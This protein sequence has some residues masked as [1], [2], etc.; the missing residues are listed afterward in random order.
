MEF[1][2]LIIILILVVLGLEMSKHVMF[3]AFAKTLVVFLIITMIFFIILGTMSSENDFKTNN[4]ILK[5]GA[6]V[7][8]EIKENPF[9]ENTIE[10]IKDF[11]GDLIK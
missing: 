10:K 7:V 8:S 2:S 6:A 1:I 3:K 9:I 11:I 4:S 5:T